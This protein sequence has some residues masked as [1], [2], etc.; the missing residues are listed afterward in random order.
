[1]QTC[2]AEFRDSVKEQLGCGRRRKFGFCNGQSFQSQLSLADEN[3]T[4]F[5]YFGGTTL[6]PLTLHKKR[7]PITIVPP[8]LLFLPHVIQRSVLLAVA[9]SHS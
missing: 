7:H 1:M 9:V 8:H 6:T 3:K 5:K 2:F 4:I